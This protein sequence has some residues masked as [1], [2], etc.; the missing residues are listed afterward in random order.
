M[1]TLLDDRRLLLP[2]LFAAVAIAV[3]SVLIVVLSDD[4]TDRGTASTS[5]APVASGAVTV[6]ITDFV[7]KPISVTVKAGST[8]TWINNDKAP[9]TATSSV[10]GAFDTGTLDKNDKKSATLDKPGTYAYIC[11]FHPFMKATVIVK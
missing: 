2:L 4:A 6:E 9:H 1:K 3:G 5:A 8:I 7:F 10:A 11:A